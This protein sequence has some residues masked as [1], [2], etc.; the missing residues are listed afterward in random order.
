MAP[1]SA[2]P[3]ELV[4]GILK[5]L[6][7]F[8]GPRHYAGC[9]LEGDGDS[10]RGCRCLEDD[11]RSSGRVATL[12][13][14]CLTSRQ[15]NSL[16]TRHL[17]HYLGCEKK[18][19]LLAATLLAR[20]D[21]AQLVMELSVF[22]S[23]P[24][25]YSDCPPEVVAYFKD[26]FQIFSA[27]MSKAGETANSALFE[28]GDKFSGSYNVPLDILLP[29][30]PNLERL[31]TAL[32]YFDAFRFLCPQSLP[33]LQRVSLSHGDTELGF[34]FGKITPLFRAAPNIT[35][36]YCWSVNGC[37]H[38]EPG[39]LA[40]IT[41]LDCEYSALGG[42]DLIN[43][44]AAC[45]NLETLKY[46]MGG[47]AVGDDQ[48]TLREVRDSVLAHAPKLKYLHLDA[49]EVCDVEEYWEEDEV[50]GL[51]HTLAERGIHLDLQMRFD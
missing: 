25:S 28:D 10:L 21:L 9:Y 4:D 13:S 31:N 7:L 5:E 1:F 11:C 51:R 16:A 19:Y 26:Q 50:E 40:K 32:W 30:C 44:F 41:S 35:D 17:Y 3:V 36:V 42:G 49:G 33:R 24:V 15:L 18:W 46:E 48:F 39:W 27:A 23:S 29:L 8:C 20:P 12:A 22:S 47:F 37:E 43:I 45:P 38:A 14:L 6:C 2:L 34:R